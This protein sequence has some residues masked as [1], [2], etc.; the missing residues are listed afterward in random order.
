[1]QVIIF[2]ASLM[3]SFTPLLLWSSLMPRIHDELVWSLCQEDGLKD[4]TARRLLS[5]TCSFSFC[6]D[7]SYLKKE[8][9]SSLYSYIFMSFLIDVRVKMLEFREIARSF[10]IR[11][12]IHYKLKL[13][14]L[15][16]QSHQWQ[17]W[18]A[19]KDRLTM[20]ALHGTGL[21]GCSLFLSPLLLSTLAVIY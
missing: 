14:N 7:S 12:E 8:K 4:R 20:A 16:S 3:I 9:K 6:E 10:L 19:Q 1:M 18:Y 11:T 13:K 21:H 2:A 15:L 17:M 5:P